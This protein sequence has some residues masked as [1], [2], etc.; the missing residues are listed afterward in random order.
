MIEF[1][2][3]HFSYPGAHSGG[4]PPEE[5]GAGATPADRGR[6]LLRAID[7]R[8]SDG[9][10]IGLVGSNGSGKSTLAKLTN[11][12]L[13]PTRGK[14]TVDGL[15]TAS[16]RDLAAIRQRVGMV[17]QNPDNQ[18]VGSIVE[19]DVAFGPEN[20]G[21]ATGE[22]AERVR[23]AL[24]HAGLAGLERRSPMALSGGQKQRL[25]VAGVLAMRPSHIVLDEAT[26]MLDPQGRRELL[27]VVRD[28]RRVH[29][30]AVVQIT[31]LLEELLGADRIVALDR[32]E[33][34]FDGPRAEFF[35]DAALLERLG[36]ESPALLT[37]YTQLRRRGL[38]GRVDPPTV[39]TL[40]GALAERAGAARTPQGRAS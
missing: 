17:F 10:H 9:E 27:E 32:G 23:W 26:A 2:G 4:A 16:G 40:A 14:V 13:L 18:I 33:I 19:D 30:I 20:L 34:V 25:A 31:H 38:V 29:G 1:S 12:L 37:L 21:L 15:D 24:D 11:G 28:L 6:P 39:E 7:L 35:D 22:I 5:R 36:L 3:V 8:I